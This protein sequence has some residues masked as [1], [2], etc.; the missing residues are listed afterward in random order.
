MLLS[1][2]TDHSSMCCTAGMK[3]EM[4]LPRNIYQEIW[5]QY[6][7]YEVKHFHAI[8]GDEYWFLE[9]YWLM[10]SSISCPLTFVFMLHIYDHLE[11]D[12]M[13]EWKHM[14]TLIA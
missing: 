8:W 9:P 14:F 4:I 3:S 1:L 7:R 5:M 2:A 12:M 13:V 11:M 10:L 6:K